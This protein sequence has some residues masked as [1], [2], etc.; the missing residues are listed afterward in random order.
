MKMFDFLGMK[1][2]LEAQSAV[3]MDQQEELDNLHKTID[4]LLKEISRRD[5]VIANR[6]NTI[7]MMQL[8]QVTVKDP[9]D[10]DFPGTEKTFDDF[11]ANFTSPKNKES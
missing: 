7:S 11:W 5:Q 2:R 6:D 9:T 1:K 10:F 8:K 3:I 4:Y